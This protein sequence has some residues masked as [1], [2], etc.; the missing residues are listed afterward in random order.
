MSKLIKILVITASVLVMVVGIGALAV[1]QKI[2]TAVERFP[3]SE[4][5]FGETIMGETPDLAAL[6][7]KV[8]VVKYWGTRCMPCLKE[9]PHLVEMQSELKDAGLAVIAPE[10]TA[11]DGEKIKAVAEAK[12]LNFSVT[13]GAKAPPNLFFFPHTVVMDRQGRCVY[14]G[15][16]IQEAEPL[17]RQA[18]SES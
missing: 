5:T 3:L 16:S 6:A 18:L 1:Y 13:K 15:T 9:L 12:N 4:M 2:H 14:S 8:V 7:G 17:I 10:M 11:R